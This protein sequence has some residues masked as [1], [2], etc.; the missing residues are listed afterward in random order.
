MNVD[1]KVMTVVPILETFQSFAFDTGEQNSAALTVT[2]IHSEQETFASS[3]CMESNV[4][5]RKTERGENIIPETSR[6]W[7]QQYRRNAFS[8]T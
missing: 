3:V 1:Y 4:K 7:A 8:T 5:K 6:A 2:E